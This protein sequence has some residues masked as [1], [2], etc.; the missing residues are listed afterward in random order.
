[1]LKSSFKCGN[2][3]H[4]NKNVCPDT[5]RRCL[6][7]GRL[8]HFARMCNK[9]SNEGKDKQANSVAFEEET[10]LRKRSH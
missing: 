9:A 7:C 4:L 3:A 6:K 2:E 1:M 5:G 10:C 8:N